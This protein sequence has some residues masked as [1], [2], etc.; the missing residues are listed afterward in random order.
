MTSPLPPDLHLLPVQSSTVPQRAAAALGMLAGDLDDPIARM[1]DA[2]RIPVDALPHLAWG[3]SADYWRDEWPEHR[4]RQVTL[5]QPAFHRLKGSIPA[6]RMACA[7]ADAELISW[8]VPRDGFVIG[9]GPT[10]EAYERWVTSLPEIRIYPLG[11]RPSRTPPLGGALGRH[12]ACRGGQ[13]ERARRAEL[14]RG[15]RV[16]PLVVSGETRGPDG[17]VLSEIERI[18]IPRAARPVLAANGAIACR[19]AASPSSRRVFSFDWRP[20]VA[21]PFHLRPGVPSLVP[22]E[23][24]PRKVAITRPHRAWRQIV[25]RTPV[26]G[27]LAPSP[28]REDWYLALRVADG[29]GPSGSRPRTGAVGRHRLPRERYTK[30]LS[31]LLARPVRR[32]FPFSG[33]RIVVDPKGKIDDVLSAIATAQVARDRVFVNFNVVRELTVADL[34]TI[35]ASTRIGALKS[36]PRR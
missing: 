2:L 16:V 1:A 20:S 10:R 31:V 27:A 3:W 29:T 34:D 32:G 19:I 12:P 28:G 13:M 21:D 24:V 14:R 18:S 35:T 7:Y 22:V 4:Q 36:L 11:P 9:A 8:H 6:D 30:E 33:R 23:A 5:E 26:T 17:V 15:A 25:G